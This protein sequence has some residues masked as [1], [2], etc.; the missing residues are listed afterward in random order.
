MSKMVTDAYEKCL[1]E[2]F[3]KFVPI[4][5]KN[6]YALTTDLARKHKHNYMAI[7]IHFLDDTM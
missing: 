7:T 3:S 6:G 5:N 4:A 2:K 1:D